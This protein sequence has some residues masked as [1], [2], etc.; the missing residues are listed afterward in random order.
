MSQ[1]A[2]AISSSL[3]SVWLSSASIARR[4]D[5]VSAELVARE[6]RLRELASERGN[7]LV[8]IVPAPVGHYTVLGQ[9]LSLSVG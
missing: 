4:I 3:I 2:G 7:P 6:Q 9:T 1:S 5:D 8:G